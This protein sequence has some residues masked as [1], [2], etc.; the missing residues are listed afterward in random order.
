MMNSR[1]TVLAIG[2]NSLIKDKSKIALWYQ[3][4]A[5]KETAVYLADLIE[6]GMNMVITHGNGPQVGFIYRR[7]E[8]AIQEL[9]LIPLDI[10]GADTQGAIGYMIEKA[11]RNQFH[12]R[13]IRQQILAV[14]TQ[15]VVDRND[16][17]FA[18]PTKP[19]GSFMTQEEALEKQKERGWNVLE[20]AGRGFRRVVPSPLPREILEVEAL[21]SLVQQGYIVIAGGGGGIPVIRNEKGELE[22][23]EAVIDK[24]LGSSL[25]ARN[26]GADTFIISTAVDEAYVNFREKNQ[27]AL[28]RVTLP[29]IKRYL[30]EGHFKA[31]SMKPKVEAIVQFLESGGEKAVITSPKNLLKAVRGEAG[32]TII[33]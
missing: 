28:R 16:P 14:V 24:D 5:V 25:L 11:L 1:L 23:V 32:T 15:T 27:K 17:S 2:G 21:R 33:R 31:G 30:G 7:G 29:E 9:P 19:I 4:E 20:D 26:L 13:S 10:C 22:G 3:Y 8:L 12:K 6:T 18:K